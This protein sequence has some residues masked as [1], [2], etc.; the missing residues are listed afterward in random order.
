MKEVIKLK[1]HDRKQLIKLSESINNLLDI[2]NTAKIKNTIKKLDLDHEHRGNIEFDY[3]KN[4]IRIYSMSEEWRV[5]N[6]YDEIYFDLI[7]IKNDKYE[8]NINDNILYK[9]YYYLI[10]TN[11]KTPKEYLPKIVTTRIEKGLK[12]LADNANDFVRKINLIVDEERRNV[13]LKEFL[14][15]KYVKL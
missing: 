7:F 15:R 8:L 11:S 10:S 9:N 6:D 4:F 3:G 12:Y 5:N 2:D 13:A 1:R 14:P